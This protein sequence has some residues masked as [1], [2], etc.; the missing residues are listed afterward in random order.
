MPSDR[1]TPISARGLKEISH[2]LSAG[3]RPPRPRWWIVL[4]KSIASVANLLI[5]I[6]GPGI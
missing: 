2:V 6:G 4:P 5:D 3:A 1:T